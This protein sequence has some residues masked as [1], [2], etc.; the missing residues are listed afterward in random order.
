MKLPVV[1]TYLSLFMQNDSPSKQISDIK[2]VAV[3]LCSLPS[4][5]P[6]ILWCSD[7]KIHEAMKN[8]NLWQILKR[9]PIVRIPSNV[10]H[11][12][13]EDA[14]NPSYAVCYHWHRQLRRIRLVLGCRLE[15]RLEQRL[16]PKLW[17]EGRSCIL[18]THDDKTQ[19]QIHSAKSGESFRD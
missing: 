12:K 16:P 9:K 17:D 18:Q 15:R 6:F 13:N 10:S 14:S 11:F 3:P 1:V 8:W 7:P 4:Q 2:Y 19:Q 5:W